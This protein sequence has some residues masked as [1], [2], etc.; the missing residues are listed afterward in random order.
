MSRGLVSN[1]VVKPPKGA[2]RHCSNNVDVPAGAMSDKWSEITS[3]L[4]IN[5]ISKK[6][7]K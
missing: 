2:A 1:V 4:S 5:K 7:I 6:I 3:I